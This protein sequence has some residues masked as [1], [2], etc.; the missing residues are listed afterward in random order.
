MVVVGVGDG[1]VGSGEEGDVVTGGAGDS[2]TAG[3]V[4]GAGEAQA[5]SVTSRKRTASRRITLL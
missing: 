4:V 5:A 2:V 1:L 3:A